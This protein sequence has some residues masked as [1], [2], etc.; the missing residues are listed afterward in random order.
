MSAVEIE[1]IRTLNAIVFGNNVLSRTNLNGKK[2]TP[3][4][5]ALIMYLQLKTS[6]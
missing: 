4:I 2:V 5:T 1:N 3:A 6:E